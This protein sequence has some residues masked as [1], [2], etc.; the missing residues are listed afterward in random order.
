MGCLDRAL[1]ELP[2]LAR[3]DGVDSGLVESV[4]SANS[5]LRSG[6]RPDCSGL[7][8][9]DLDATS[10]LAECVSPFCDLV[11]AIIGVGS[12]KQMI[13]VDAK[14]VVAMVANT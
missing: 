13:R 10:P 6:V 1:G 14:L 7:L 11:P 2:C 12:Q 5:L 4:L 3:L 8:G 9:I